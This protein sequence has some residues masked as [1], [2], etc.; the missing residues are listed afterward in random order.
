[1]SQPRRVGAL[2]ALLAIAAGVVTAAPPA[3]A[4]PGDFYN[5]GS[6]TPG[7]P[8]A[9]VRRE[10]L[11]PFGGLGSGHRVLYSSTDTFGAPILVS[12]TALEPDAAWT[13][14]GRVP[15]VVIGPGTQGQ[16]D[17][18]APS[19]NFEKGFGTTNIG[20]ETSIQANYEGFFAASFLAQGFRVFVTD[21]VGLGTPGVHTYANR[22]EAAHAM[23]DG[24]RA[25]SPGTGPIVLWGHSQGGAATAAAAELAP[26]YAPDL[27]IAAGYA[28][29]P[30]ADL[31]A[32][33]RHIDGTGLM[34]AIGYT[35]NG[36]LAR[37]PEL[38]DP[39]DAHLNDHGRAVLADV[40]GQCLL[41]SRNEYGR[42]S[43]AGWTTDGRRLDEV[44]ADLPA[45]R[46]V[47]DEQRIGRRTPAAPIMVTGAENDD[48]IPFSQTTALVRD[49]CARGASIV[50]NT[51]RIPA[52]NPGSGNN[53]LAPVVA[54]Y[55]VGLQFVRD[56]LAGLP[57]EGGC[58]TV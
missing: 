46:T 37:Y 6:V 20:G 26:E 4:A 30:P 1:M 45:A 48:F 25:A 33:Q 53:H 11:V 44:I 13:G 5:T 21:Y 32:V 8:G 38:R 51:D 47:A 18:C 29:S 50:L 42:Q 19:R 34:A 3:V 31:I 17:Q 28:S 15:L 23:L 12:G 27:N 57:V 10:A 49:W 22:A 52:V 7:D 40:A 58:A 56:R 35:I 2:F 16:G 36:F 39:L 54:D 24:A 9:V 14:P 55:P 43:T 41:D